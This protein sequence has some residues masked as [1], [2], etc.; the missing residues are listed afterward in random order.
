MAVVFGAN[1]A[2]SFH[3]LFLYL[4]GNG[5]VGEKGLKHLLKCTILKEIMQVWGTGIMFGLES[6]IYNSHRRATSSRFR[7]D[8]SKTPRESK[9]K[10]E[11]PRNVSVHYLYQK[12]CCDVSIVKN[13][14]SKNHTTKTNG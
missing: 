13:D 12:N 10:Q 1:A 2:C 14:I 4:E 8:F 6:K 5:V 3:F 9:K 7:D 11:K